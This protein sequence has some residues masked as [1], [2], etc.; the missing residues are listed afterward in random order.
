MIIIIGLGN[1][2]NKFE[3]TRHNLGQQIISEVRKTA[4][5]P[6]FKLS[7]RFKALIS[8]GEIEMISKGETKKQPVYLVKPQTFMNLSGFTVR[9]IFNFWKSK[10]SLN[11]HPSSSPQNLLQ[12]FADNLIVV[13]DDIDIPLGKIKF[14]QNRGSA[15]HKGVASIIQTLGTKNF[16]RMRLGIQPVNGKPKEVDKFV[17]QRF[18]REE[19]EILKNFVFKKANQLLLAEL[20]KDYAPQRNR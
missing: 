19:K 11:N 18:S 10:I 3:W 17:L 8:K 14:C 13:H 5:L 4:N 9:K 6:P 16:K 15:G 20:T 12:Q 2:G 7:K 1:P